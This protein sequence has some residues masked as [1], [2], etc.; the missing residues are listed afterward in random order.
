[1]ADED[2]AD[3]T[4][5]AGR[6]R[7]VTLTL[8]IVAGIILIV[9]IVVTTMYFTGYF[10][11]DKSTEV[12]ETILQ[13]EKEAEA[14]MQR[15]QELALGPKKETLTAPELSRFENTYFE[16]DRKLVVN[17]RDSRK[18]MQ[19]QVAIMTHYDDRVIAN[20]E[21]HALSIRS[22]MLDI[23]SRVEEAAIEQPG[24]RRALAHDLRL[25]INSVLEKYEDFGGVEEVLFSEFVIQ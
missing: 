16:I 14:T 9:L 8:A 1:M 12:E 3:E 25:G 23:M 10:S 20:L 11:D 13:L 17:I 21:K 19:V 22:E 5:S 15:A 24:F 2:R 18:V 4:G 7:L 6:S